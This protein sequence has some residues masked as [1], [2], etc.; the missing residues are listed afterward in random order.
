MVAGVSSSTKQGNAR[1]GS[2]SIRAFLEETDQVGT[3][4]DTVCWKLLTVLS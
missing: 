1:G 4:S 3:T 2:G